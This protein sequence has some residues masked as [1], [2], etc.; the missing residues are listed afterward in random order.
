MKKIYIVFIF[1]LLTSDL[2]YAFD[3][4]EL[5]NSIYNF[6]SKLFFP[7]K[8]KPSFFYQKSIEVKCNPCTAKKCECS[9]NNC[10]SGLIN[11]Y[12]LEG[13]SSTPKY[14]LE[15]SEPMKS[16]V[17]DS[18]GDYYI[19]VLCDD[20]SIGSCELLTISDLEETAITTTVLET[21]TPE[22]TPT[23]TLIGY[24]ISITNLQFLD[25]N[26][27][28]VESI[29]SG[30]KYYIRSNIKN[31]GLNEQNALLIVQII[32][33]NGNVL[34]PI[35]WNLLKLNSQEEKYFDIEYESNLPGEYTVNVFVWSDWASM[36]GL[37]LASKTELKLKI[38]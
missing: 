35:K 20:E 26:K 15:F 19:R 7:K 23:T 14:I 2:I 8:T 18:T 32:D 11:V 22:T 21:T 12:N 3:F 37:A 36:G 31:N 13:C 17:P 38:V 4:G 34:L 1:I 5:S 29:N 30:N 28:I 33:S 9:I 6:F 27:E 10:N 25:S 24:P 16:W